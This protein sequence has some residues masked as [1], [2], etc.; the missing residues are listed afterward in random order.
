MKALG[1]VIVPVFVVTLLNP[2]A[3]QW[4]PFTEAL[5]CVKHLQYFH[6]TAQY[7]YHTEATMEYM[8]NYLE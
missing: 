7:Q 1:H 5:L 6:L 3:N 2:L 8:E 4:I